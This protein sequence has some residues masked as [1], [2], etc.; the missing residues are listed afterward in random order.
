M[1]Y[2]KIINIDFKSPVKN[3]SMEVIENC[4][5]LI[6]SL[7]EEIKRQFFEINGK[8]YILVKLKIKVTKKI[9]GY[10]LILGYNE[11]YHYKHKNNHVKCGQE[12]IFYSSKPFKSIELNLPDID[13]IVVNGA[14]VFVKCPKVLINGLNFE[15]SPEIIYH[16][17]MLKGGSNNSVTIG[18]GKVEIKTKNEPII[19]AFANTSGGALDD[20]V[21]TAKEVATKM[22]DYTVNEIIGEIEALI[23]G[24]KG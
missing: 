1:I 23:N 19:K 9:I 12:V 11:N 15:Y 10:T 4:N 24:L 18:S 8:E 7:P 5:Y 22:K 2:L 3:F 21:T 16:K 20:I 6:S 17:V 14:S 13:G